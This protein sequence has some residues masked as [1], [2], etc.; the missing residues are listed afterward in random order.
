MRREYP[1]RPII[2]VGVVVWH[3]GRVLLVRRRRPPRQD[4]WSLPGGAQ[5]LGESLADAAR[6]E[7]LEETGITVELGDLIATVA[8]SGE[9]NTDRSFLPDIHAAADE[10][11]DDV[12]GG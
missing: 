2:G 4:Q 10:R 6:R 8:W 7:V 3:G 9:A 12:A 1:T 5:Q 11:L